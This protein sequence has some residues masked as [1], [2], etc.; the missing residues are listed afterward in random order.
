MLKRI[1]EL[2]E[3]FPNTGPDPDEDVTVSAIALE[4]GIVKNT[5]I[6]WLRRWK[7]SPELSVAERLKDLP[8]TGCPD[9]FTAEQICKITA[10]CCESPSEYGRPITHWTH[11]VLDRVD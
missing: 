7:G 10:A 3:S 4:L 6:K 5:V 2:R 1:F 9:K 11:R 8:R